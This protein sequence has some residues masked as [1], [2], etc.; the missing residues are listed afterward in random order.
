ML[1]LPVVRS[2]ASGASMSLSLA[3]LR[4]QSGPKLV[5]F[6]TPRSGRRSS[7]RRRRRRD[8]PRTRR[9]PPPRTRPSGSS[10][11]SVR[12]SPRARRRRGLVAHG[13]E[14][15][16]PG[17]AGLVADDHLARDDLG[18]VEPR[19]VD[20]AGAGAAGGSGNDCCRRSQRDQ[21]GKPPG[22]SDMPKVSQLAPL[23]YYLA[24][25]PGLLGRC[26]VGVADFVGR[27]DLER[28]GA[29]LEVLVAL[30]R[31]AGRPRALVELAFEGRARLGGGE[32]E[33]RLPRLRRLLRAA[34]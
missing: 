20:E 22:A 19:S 4:P 23:R 15:L 7:A 8:R 21:A 9:S 29:L 13:A 33:R 6:G 26:P 16:G 24:D 34:R 30:C 17:R 3:W 32:L 11:S 12:G 25:L 28:V 14:P 27:L 2:Q 1:E 10:T 18:A 5:S 31:L